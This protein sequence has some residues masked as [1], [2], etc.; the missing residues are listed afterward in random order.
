MMRAS[1]L[2]M[3]VSSSEGVIE[4]RAARFLSSLTKL[5]RRGP[6]SSLPASTQW[7]SCSTSPTGTA[8]IWA[9]RCSR[10]FSSVASSFLCTTPLAMLGRFQRMGLTPPHPCPVRRWARVDEELVLAAHVGQRELLL[11]CELLPDAVADQLHHLCD[12]DAR[13][14]HIALI[15][16]QHELHCELG[17]LGDQVGAAL[18]R[19]VVYS[20]RD[21]CTRAR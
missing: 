3:A 15:A 4:D 18:P 16:T 8:H 9:S 21:V 14:V 13:V 1:S 10:R 17:E 7:S 5:A 2:E 19:H 6:P 20:R 11:G 12:P